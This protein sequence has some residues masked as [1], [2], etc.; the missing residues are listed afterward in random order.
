MMRKTIITIF[1]VI[2]FFLQLHAQSLSDSLLA[3][4]T[5]SNNL[6][7]GS[8]NHYD[9]LSASGIFTTDRFNQSNA[10]FAFDGIN[11]S[12]VLPI[13]EMAPVSGDFAISFWYKTNSAKIMNLFSSKQTPDDT[14]HNF[15]M[16]L[17]SHNQYYLEYYQ[18]VW[19]QTFVYWN[20]SGVDS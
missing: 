10:A 16:Q 7:D 17:N 20:G 8:E 9:I 15:E 5:F 14:T 4:Y 3:H 12:L 11:D 19:Y 6:L 18:Q 1:S 13:P 2:S